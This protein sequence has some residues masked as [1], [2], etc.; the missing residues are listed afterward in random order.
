MEAVKAHPSPQERRQLSVE[1]PGD[2]PQ[3][4][5]EQAM[6]DQQ[7]I[8]APSGS[9]IQRRLARVHGC[10][11]GGDVGRSGHL[12]TV[13]GVRIVREGR[14]LERVLEVPTAIKRDDALYMMGRAYQELRQP[15]K[16]RAIVD[17]FRKRG[18]YVSYDEQ[19]SIG[20]RYAKHDEIGV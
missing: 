1:R 14:D 12:Q 16:A 2:G 9:V 15:E 13:P 17:T 8:Q 10:A 18:L 19:Q 20:K 3:P 5:P 7:E 11:D 4:S 6:V